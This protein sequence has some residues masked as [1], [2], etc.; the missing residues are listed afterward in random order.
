MRRLW[1]CSLCALSLLS[2]SPQILWASHGNLSSLLENLFV[3]DITLDPTL[4]NHTTVFGDRGDALLDF[5]QSLND[6]IGQQLSTFP[7]GSSSG[8]F[9]YDFDPTLGVF[10][11]STASFG[12][13]YAERAQTIG[14]G[15]W[16]IGASF[17]RADYDS[18]DGLALNDG[19][20]RTQLIHAD[21]NG[22]GFTTVAFFEGDVIEAR[23]RIDVSTD[24]LV[25]FGTYGLHDRLDFTV[26]VP[27]I[28]VSLTAVSENEIIRLSTSATP[29]IHVFDN[30]TV[31]ETR[32]AS[33]SA[34][35]IGDVLMRGKYRFFESG[36]VAWALGLDLR[37]P[38]GDE[39]ELLGTGSLQGRA[40][41]IGSA[42]IG[43]FS[44]HMNFGFTRTLSGELPDEINY[45]FG[46]DLALHPRVTFAV[47][48]V[49][50]T[51][52]DATRFGLEGQTFEFTQP[53]PVVVETAV[54]PVL[55]TEEDD[56]NQ[57]FSAVGFK[58]NPGGSILVTVNALLSLRDEGLRDDDIVWLIGIESTF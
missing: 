43:K 57:L 40:L 16:N 5:T 15:K 32:Q 2:L 52:L 20:I 28:K 23:A 18:L 12:P 58:F 3:R 49:G 36:G 41:V 51:L 39:D 55:V 14:K 19:E 25:I 54:R 17:Q 47:D 24:T 8:G 4:S 10:R 13:I 31:L 44:P 9:T 37:L 45:V 29:G 53:G 42:I 26:A 50:R 22:D 56:I 46:F 38:T 33:D 30:G 21:T 1:S 35:G 27:L 34:T 7:L 6:S 48:L 11:R